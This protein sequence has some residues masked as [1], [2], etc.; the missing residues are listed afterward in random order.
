MIIEGATDVA[1][2]WYATNFSGIASL[3]TLYRGCGGLTFIPVC[4]PL[5]RGSLYVG[6]DPYGTAEATYSAICGLPGVTIALGSTERETSICIPYSKHTDYVKIQYPFADVDNQLAR[7]YVV[8]QAPLIAPVNTSTRIEILVYTWAGEDAEFK[9]PLPLPQRVAIQQQGLIYQSLKMYDD[10]SLQPGFLIGNH[11]NL[12]NLLRRPEYYRRYVMNNIDNYVTAEGNR[13]PLGGIHK[14][15]TQLF[16]YNSGGNIIQF[17][18]DF[19][20]AQSVLGY[21]SFKNDSIEHPFDR[22]VSGISGSSNDIWEGALHNMVIDNSLNLLMPGYNHVPYFYNSRGLTPNEDQ[23]WKMIISKKNFNSFDQPND[24]NLGHSVADDFMLYI[25]M[26][27]YKL[28]IPIAQEVN[29][30]VPLMTSNSQA[31]FIVTA[32]SMS[33]TNWFQ[34]FDRNLA[35]NVDLV[36][37]PGSFQPSLTINFPTGNTIQIEQLFLSLLYADRNQCSLKFNG[38]LGGTQYNLLQWNNLEGPNGYNSPIVNTWY[39]S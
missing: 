8:V 21:F 30:I 29:G 34:A 39:D 36:D 15:I 2:T 7:I 26:S 27:M 19:N 14:I 4:T 32:D 16:K 10:T 38:F 11:S 24:V 12:L 18:T 31:G 13:L 3:F 1:N 20:M 35:T 6:Q 28:A 33:T 22:T 25:P 23:S 17:A 9:Y 37:A 5:Q